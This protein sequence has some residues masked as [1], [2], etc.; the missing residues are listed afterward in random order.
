MLDDAFPRSIYYSVREAEHSLAQI[1]AVAPHISENAAAT[2]LAGLRTEL[3]QT[4]I[5]DIINS[6]LH[7][8]LDDIQSKIAEIHAAVQAVFITY[9][10]A[11]AHKC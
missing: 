10:T 4:A 11:G 3:E 1:T 5:R 7:E 6:G 2:L 9:P 8:Y